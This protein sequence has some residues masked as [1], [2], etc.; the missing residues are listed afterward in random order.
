MTRNELLANLPASDARVYCS[1]EKPEW[2]RAVYPDLTF[3]YVLDADTAT[4]WENGLT[5]LEPGEVEDSKAW[6]LVP[7]LP[8]PSGDLPDGTRVRLVFE[9]TVRHWTNGGGNL[10]T[11]KGALFFG[12]G[13][14]AHGAVEVLALPEPPKVSALEGKPGSLWRDPRVGAVWVKVDLEGLPRQFSLV[15]GPR[16]FSG[17]IPGNRFDDQVIARL[18]PAEVS[19]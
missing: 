6:A 7:T 5:K 10:Q 3:W 14:F 15:S 16:K 9:G 2:L 13:D 1:T 4:E 18:V 19:P 12:R 17:L 8:D 11:E